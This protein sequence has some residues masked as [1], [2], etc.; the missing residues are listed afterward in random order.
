MLEPLA[1]AANIAQADIC[2]PDQVLLIFGSLIYQYNRMRDVDV[3]IA[4][5]CAILASLEKR[6]EKCEQEVYI[7][8]TFVNPFVRM[9]PFKRKYN[10]AQVR[11]SLYTP[12]I[13]IDVLLP[14]VRFVLKAIQAV[15]QGERGPRG[16]V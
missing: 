7:A 12:R 5:R 1:K 2:R 16:S 8:T 3:D 14:V 13:V 6:W 10:T 9:D 15:F 11:I 4:G